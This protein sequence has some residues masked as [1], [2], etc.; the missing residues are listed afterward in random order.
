M[1]IIDGVDMFFILKYSFLFLAE[2]FYELKFYKLSLYFYKTVY[3]NNQNVLECLEHI[4]SC[5]GYLG[6][7]GSVIKYSDR[8]LELDKNNINVFIF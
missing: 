2:L 7:Y 8:Y 5:Y 6:E 4:I 1:F 3:Q